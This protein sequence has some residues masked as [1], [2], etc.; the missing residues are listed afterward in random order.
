MT[1]RPPVPWPNDGSNGKPSLMWETFHHTSIE[2]TSRRLRG[3]AIV[4]HIFIRVWVRASGCLDTEVSCKE[5]G[6][7]SFEHCNIFSLI[8]VIFIVGQV[9]AALDQ[10]FLVPNKSQTSA[11]YVT[12]VQQKLGTGQMLSVLCMNRNYL[13]DPSVNNQG[14]VWNISILHAVETWLKKPMSISWSNC[15]A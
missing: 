1:M 2:Q 4:I 5:L 3:A 15:N 8:Q 9:N 7:N 10:S 6:P 14:E 13:N 12:S 11:I